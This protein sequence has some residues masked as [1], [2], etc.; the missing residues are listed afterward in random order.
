MSKVE[1]KFYTGRR[2]ASLKAFL[3]GITTISDAIEKFTSLGIV[4]PID[5]ISAHFQQNSPDSKDIEEVDST[6][7]E[8][9][10]DTNITEDYDDLVNDFLEEEAF[11]N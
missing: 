5:L 9:S 2:K 7:N 6:A 8:K 4:P 11:E 3:R 1:W 10:E